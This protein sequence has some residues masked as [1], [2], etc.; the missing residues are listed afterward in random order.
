MN[1]QKHNQFEKCI[2]LCYSCGKMFKEFKRNQIS[3][4][5]AAETYIF[6]FEFFACFRLLQLG[7]ADANEIKHDNS[8]VV[9]VVLDPHL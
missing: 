2:V 7:G 1:T 5:L 3:V 9:Y 4:P 8:F 6:I